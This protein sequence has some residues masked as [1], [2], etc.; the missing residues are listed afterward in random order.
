MQLD[1]LALVSV[2][3]GYRDVLK[4]A[5]EDERFE[6]EALEEELAIA[7]AEVQ[8]LRKK[9]GECD[10]ERRELK[11]VAAT[12]DSSRKLAREMAAE[13]DKYKQE[14][15]NLRL[16]TAQTTEDSLARKKQADDRHGAFELQLLA[17]KERLVSS[18]TSNARDRSQLT[19]TIESLTAELHEKD[20]ALHLMK[21]QA[22]TDQLRSQQD[23]DAQ[24]REALSQAC[25]YVL[26]TYRV[27]TFEVRRR[28]LPH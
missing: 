14:A 15:Y 17:L 16:H 2:Q 9:Y 11:K 3:E 27:H 12:V 24:L 26:R 5:L 4:E 28:E 1:R 7:T 10:V 18:Q 19:K 13:R 20:A 21:E 25:L 23:L 8:D 22:D 6:K